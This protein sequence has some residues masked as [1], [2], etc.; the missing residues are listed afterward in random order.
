[1]MCQTG[2]SACTL[3]CAPGAGGY[4]S[5]LWSCSLSLPLSLCVSQQGENKM[6]TKCLQPLQRTSL[7]LLSLKFLSVQPNNCFITR[8]N[9]SSSSSTG[10][11][12]LLHFLQY[13]SE[14]F[15]WF[16]L[17]R[18]KCAGVINNRLFGLEI[19]AHR[20][21]LK[22]PDEP[23]IRAKAGSRGWY[24]QSQAVSLHLK[25]ESFLW[26]NFTSRVRS[27]IFFQRSFILGSFTLLMLVQNI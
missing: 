14:L 13:N 8:K 17:L 16:C 20:V 3:F 18:G 19:T 1:M 12:S 23:F 27:S 6:M 15:F 4:Y 9:S 26:Q 21:A 11:G 10:Q 22:K 25:S 2:Y 7:K 5:G 24:H